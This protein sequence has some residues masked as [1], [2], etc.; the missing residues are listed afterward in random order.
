VTFGE[1]AKQCVPG[2]SRDEGYEALLDGSGRCSGDAGGEHGD[3][4]N[5]GADAAGD[6]GCAPSAGQRTVALVALKAK[7]SGAA[8]DSVKVAANL[9]PGKKTTAHLAHE[10]DCLFDLQGEFADGQEIDETG[11]ELCKD[12]MINLTD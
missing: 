9:G 6:A 3:G 8:G 11:V 7:I 4:A 5:G 10:K 1:A 12:K 2:R